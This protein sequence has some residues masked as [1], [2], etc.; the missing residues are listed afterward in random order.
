VCDLL[1]FECLVELLVIIADGQDGG[2][3]LERRHRVVGWPGGTMM[4]GSI[5]LAAT[6]PV[7]CAFGLGKRR[8]RYLL[9]WPNGGE[10]G[11]KMLC[12]QVPTEGCATPV[13]MLA[14]WLSNGD[15]T[16]T[17]HYGFPARLVS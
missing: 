9:K 10:Q 3:D 15:G 4:R 7:K 2:G 6:G 17:L 16:K 11:G 14:S 1:T 5:N 8:A 13:V 12:E